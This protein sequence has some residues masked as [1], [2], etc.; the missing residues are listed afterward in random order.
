L[1]EVQK[2]ASSSA[3]TT[4]NEKSIDDQ[5]HEKLVKVNTKLKRAL[6]TVKDKIHRLVAERP[7]LFADTSDDTIER[8]DHLISTVSN[9]ATQIDI[10]QA[11]RDQAEEQLRNEIREL[12]R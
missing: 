9:Q 10:L 11:E 8:L 1:E 3:Q 7:D 2:N 5:Q 12:Q 6:Q 4:D